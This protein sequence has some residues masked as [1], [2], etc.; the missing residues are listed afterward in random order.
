MICILF[1]ALMDGLPNANS[2]CDRTIKG[3]AYP[4]LPK[5]H[6]LLTAPGPSPLLQTV[7]GS[8][9][10][11]YDLISGEEQSVVLTVS[12]L[13]GQW[14]WPPIPPVQVTAST[15][16]QAGPVCRTGCD[17]TGCRCNSP[18]MLEDV[19]HLLIR[20][21][22]IT[23][24]C[25]CGD[26]KVSNN[27]QYN[28]QQYP[29]RVS[30]QLHFQAQTSWGWCTRLQTFST[31]RGPMHWSFHLIM[32]SSKQEKSTVENYTST[33]PQVGLKGVQYFVKII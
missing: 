23:R 28:T 30:F 22:N 20:V 25:F 11:Q 7:S 18:H 19:D 5:L 32:N 24:G 29:S 12:D 15:P 1:P 13:T 14:L 3:D 33:H 27:T 16:S 8:L 9:S 26:F 4:F 21:R 17:G 31:K 6:G 10:C 2:T